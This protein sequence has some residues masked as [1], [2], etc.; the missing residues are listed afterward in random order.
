[1]R[2]LIALVVSL[3]TLPVL[4]QEFPLTIDS[5][6]GPVRLEKPAERIIVFSEE[7]T[8]VFIALDVAPV[9]VGT[10]RNETSAAPFTKLP[11]LD[12]PIPGSP[13][14]FNGWEI[15]FEQVLALEPDLIFFHMNADEPE[16]ETIAKLEAMA[17]VIG[18]V[19]SRPG[20]W[21]EVARDLGLAT[22][23]SDDAETL[24][25]DFETRVAQLQAQMAPIVAEHPTVTA[26]FAWGESSGYFDER[27]SIGG[28]LK[29]L[30]LTL[31]TPL[32]DA[33][34]ASGFDVAPVESVAQIDADTIF[35][36]RGGESPFDDLLSR[37][38]QPVLEEPLPPG[39]GH[40]GPYA[41]MLY[42]EAIAEK[43]QAQ[44]AP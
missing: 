40:S 41:E 29:L 32:G 19:G 20:A 35:V 1:M 39:I 13:A 43:Y 9:G 33:M 5:D 27:F 7:Y 26:V 34:P 44:Y 31:T 37:R 38:S 23:K 18:I 25:A 21:K 36:I 22:G 14:G 28:H 11:Y 24:I 8:E 17:P 2:L 16:L 30:G 12:K 6:S 42:L 15:N 10:W 3:L 4:A